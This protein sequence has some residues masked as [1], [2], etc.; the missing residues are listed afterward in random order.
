[1]MTQAEFDVEGV[2]GV[3]EEAPLEAPF[4]AA[5]EDLGALLVLEA[6]CKEQ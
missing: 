2:E 1:M 6:M 3:E 5:T 4:F